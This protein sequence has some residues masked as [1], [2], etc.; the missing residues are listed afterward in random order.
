MSI[1]SLE[2]AE[3][4]RAHYLVRCKFGRAKDY[5]CTDCD[6]P[7]HDW[8]WEHDTDPWDVNNY[9]PRCKSCHTKYDMTPEWAAKSAHSRS[10][11]ERSIIARNRM[12]EAKKRWHKQQREA[13]SEIR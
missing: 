9:W 2:G 4:S 3:Y 1:K 11:V 13:A 8:S 12:S 5:Q 7:A 10:G 6:K